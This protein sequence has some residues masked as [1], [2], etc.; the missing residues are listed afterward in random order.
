MMK[1]INTQKAYIAGILDGEG[2]IGLTRDNTAGR[3]RP[4]VVISNCNLPLLVYI[5]TIIGGRLHKKT[6]IGTRYQ[7]YNLSIR[8]FME[9]LPQITPYLVGKKNKSVLLMEALKI[10]AVRRKKT[11]AAGDYGL[12]RLNEIDKLLR[13]K[14]WL[15]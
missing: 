14:E 7:G 8:H 6:R 4:R 2:Y 12:K 13:K 10:L 15:I 5:Q 1:I 11:A 3:Y 9:W